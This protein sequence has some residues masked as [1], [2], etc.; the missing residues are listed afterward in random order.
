LYIA[1]GIFRHNVYDIEEG[2]ICPCIPDAVGGWMALLE[3]F[4]LS[5]AE[6]PNLNVNL[7]SFLDN[8]PFAVFL[9]TMVAF[10]KVNIVKTAE[11]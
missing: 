5:Q 3:S 10:W 7:N 2:V 4:K 11:G 6:K 1:L 9:M 8:K